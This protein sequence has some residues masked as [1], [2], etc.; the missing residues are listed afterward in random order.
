MSIGAGITDDQL[1]QAR[2][3]NQ[4]LDVIHQSPSCVDD[5]RNATGFTIQ[6]INWIMRGLFAADVVSRER[7]QYGHYTYRITEL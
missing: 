1:R 2:N 4:V 7:P 5:I 3:D 6:Q